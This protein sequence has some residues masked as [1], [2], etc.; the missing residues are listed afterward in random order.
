MT[1]SLSPWSTSGAE[2]N[3]LNIKFDE[4]FEVEGFKEKMATKVYYGIRTAIENI[5]LPSFMAAT[6]IFGR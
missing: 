4:E 3:Q 5:D 6:N 1:K 2:G